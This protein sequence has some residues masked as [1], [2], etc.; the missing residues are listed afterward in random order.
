MTRKKKTLRN[1]AAKPLNVFKS[2]FRKLWIGIRYVWDRPIIVSGI[3]LVLAVLLFSVL[4]KQTFKTYFNCA[5]LI[6][7]QLGMP[8]FFCAG[9]DVKVFGSSVFTI[10]GL[11]GVMDPPLEI[12]R[13][14]V[15]WIILLFFAL[16]SIYLTILINNLKAV[17]K[18]LT[19]NKEEWKRFMASLRT[20]LLIFVTFCLTFYFS[21]IR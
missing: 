8:S 11:T 13:K 4:L 2:L 21:V 18:L 6:G 15:S 14:V 16:L 3:L 7:D 10:P 20:W 12:V 1:W 17:V 9:H 19:L 5:Y